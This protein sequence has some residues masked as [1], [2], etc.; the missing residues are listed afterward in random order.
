MR[1]KAGEELWVW[2]V[3]RRG[4]TCW[5]S[6]YHSSHKTDTESSAVFAGICRGGHGISN[7]IIEEL[8]PGIFGE[9]IRIWGRPVLRWIY[10]YDDIG[11]GTWILSLVGVLFCP[12]S[13]HILYIE[14]SPKWEEKI[15]MN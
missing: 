3:V 1:E 2:R 8:V 7:V 10:D 4:R 11:R 14:R 13:K 9:K 12:G 15:C 5:G 6:V